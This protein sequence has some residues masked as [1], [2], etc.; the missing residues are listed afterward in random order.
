[1]KTITREAETAIET[2]RSRFIGRSFIRQIPA[3]ALAAV[4]KLRAH[5]RDATHHC[6]AY[7]IGR[8]GEQARYNDDGEPQGT[9]G[10]PILEVLK[11][12]DVTNALLVVTRYYGGIKLGAGGLARAYGEAAKRVLEESGIKELRLMAEIEAAVPYPL[13][14]ALE[15]YLA[16]AEAEV[17]GKTF[18]EFVTV[19]LR[20]TAD[21][22]DDFEAF[23]ARLTSGKAS[24]SILGREYK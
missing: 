19:R 5:E 22:Q 9:A 20:I 21:R 13:L 7:R 11:K 8:D 4:E 18:G 2:K 1:M 14:G 17:A 24:F 23:Y 12:N 15:H 10:P 6:W 3:E 16:Q